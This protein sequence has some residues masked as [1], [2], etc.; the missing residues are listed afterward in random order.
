[1]FCV[2]ALIGESFPP[3]TAALAIAAA[4][5]Q[6]E[7]EH[8]SER[9]SRKPSACCAQWRSIHTCAHLYIE[10]LYTCAHL[11]IEHL[12][13][14]HLYIKHRCIHAPHHVH[15]SSEYVITLVA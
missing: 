7:E 8:S 14:E 12:Y 4:V 5:A 9:V 2:S 11:Y 15:S 10:H 3:H 6:L 13:I 1:M